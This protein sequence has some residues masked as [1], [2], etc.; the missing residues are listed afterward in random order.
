MVGLGELDEGV[1]AAV[2]E[3][4]GEDGGLFL[5]RFGE[6]VGCDSRPLEEEVL[7]G[8]DGWGKSLEL[9]VVGLPDQVRHA[10]LEE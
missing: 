5:W 10:R 1:G 4:V 2:G 9:D 6:V 3:G 7:E 8:F